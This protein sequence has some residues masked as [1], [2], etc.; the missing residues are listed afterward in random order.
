MEIF[1]DIPEYEGLYQV[2]NY[3]NIKSVSREVW[4]GKIYYKS[5]ERILKPKLRKNGYLLVT[6][7][8]NNIQKD[9]LI[10][11][12]VAIS[13]IPNPNNF[14]EIDHIDNNKRNNK[15]ENL[16]W[17]NHKENC[18]NPI[19]LERY[20]KDKEILVVQL[21]LNGNLVKLW[22][23][24]RQAEREG[25]FISGHIC[26]CCKGKSKTHKGYKWMYYE[27]YKD[28]TEVNK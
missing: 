14:T 16:K 19:T 8:K 24:T 7:S 2:S 23:S 27:D 26:N 17:C 5:K 15:V 4:N 3:G 11:R 10:H 6:L 12:L 25:G 1:K 22:E 28:N 9:W 13:F 20:N 21:D 18:N